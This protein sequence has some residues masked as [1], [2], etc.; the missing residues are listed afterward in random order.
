[1]EILFKL[2]HAS[3]QQN[4]Y[5]NTSWLFAV[6]KLILKFIGK[7]KGPRIAKTVLN[8]AEQSWKIHTF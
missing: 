2:I 5:Q 6:D 3:I 4:T 7:F 8:R 1:M